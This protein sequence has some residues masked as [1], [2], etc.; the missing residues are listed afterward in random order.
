MD[1]NHLRPTVLAADLALGRDDY[2]MNFIKDF[3][4]RSRKQAK[5]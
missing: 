1:A 5:T 2:A 4:K 3:R